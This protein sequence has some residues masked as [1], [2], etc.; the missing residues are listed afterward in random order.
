MGASISKPIESTIVERHG[1]KCFNV[2]VAEMNGRRTSMEDAHLIMMRDTWGLFGVFDGHGGAECSRFVSQKMR[3][4]IEQSGCPQDD[5]SAKQIIMDIDQQFLDSQ[6]GSGTTA[7]MCIVRPPATSGERH[8]LHVI[9]IGDSRV[10]LGR[11]DGT[12][13]DGG[14]TDKGL[15]TDHKPTNPDEESRINRCGGFVRE[16]RVNGQL[17]VSRAFGDREYKKTGGPGLEDRPV[18][19]DPEFGHFECDDNHFLLLVCDGVSESDFPN[20]EVVRFAASKLEEL[21]DPGLVAKAVCQRALDKLSNDNITCMVVLLNG[22]G[23]QTPLVEFQPGP[24]ADHSDVFIAAW[25]GMAERAGLSLGEALE[26]R[27]ECVLD[28]LHAS[29][30][31]DTTAW[32]EELRRIG[33]P[34]GDKGSEERARWWESWSPSKPMPQEGCL[35]QHDVLTNALPWLTGEVQTTS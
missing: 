28:L 6:Q 9:N 26:M 11:K 22:G 25:T 35:T 29:D 32:Q 30:G 13:V 19:A 20:E 17:A 23:P 12:I 8:Q 34:Q 16:L 1:S 4:E 14:G 33:E 7:T 18:T 27:Y 15:T 10:L 21:K 5:A 31:G 3:S 24:L 2:G